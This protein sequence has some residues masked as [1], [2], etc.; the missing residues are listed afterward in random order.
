MGTGESDPLPHQRRA[1]ADALEATDAELEVL[2]FPTSE[3]EQPTG[4]IAK[5]IEALE[6]APSI[7]AEGVQNRPVLRLLGHAHHAL[8]DV[9]F[10]RLR[11]G[12]A[13]DHY[14][15]AHELA[16]EIGDADMAALALTQLG[17]IARRRRRYRAALRLFESADDNSASA[18][19][20]TQVQHAQTVAR[21]HAEFG[22]RS[23]FDNAIGHAEQ[24]ANWV[25]PEHHQE[26]DHSP[27]GVRFER[28]QGYTVLGDAAAALAIYESEQPTFRTM[29]ERGNFLIIHAQAIALAGHLDEGIRLAIEGLDLARTYDSPRHVSRVQRMHD[30]LTTVWAPSEPHLAELSEALAG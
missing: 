11:F 16:L 25:A 13:A 17:D 7:T 19:A 27:R 24:L 23:A 14:H 15:Q 5:V 26:G 9:A 2:L 29:R 4:D 6:I 28:A 30:R 21:A 8:G 3:A 12:D 10:D 22:D 1:I 20:L 18:A